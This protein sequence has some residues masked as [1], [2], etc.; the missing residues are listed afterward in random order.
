[1]LLIDQEAALQAIPQL[2]PADEAARREGLAALREVLS[3]RGELSGVAADRWRQ[4][5]GLFGVDDEPQSAAP[6]AKAPRDSGLAKA[7]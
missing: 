2:L 1:M 6:K 5:V 7:S 4:I 3:A